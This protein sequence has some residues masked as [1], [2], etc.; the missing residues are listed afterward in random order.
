MEG[1]EIILADALNVKPTP[2]Q[3]NSADVATEL[4]KLYYTSYA[5]DEPNEIAETYAKFYATAEYLRLNNRT[6]NKL[7]PED[8]I[9]LVG[10]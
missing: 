4:T 5:F 1:G 6:L 8:I 3:R 10:R 2:I 7:V 9:K